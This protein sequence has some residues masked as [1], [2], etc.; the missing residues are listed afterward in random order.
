VAGIYQRDGSKFWMARFKGPDGD[1]TARSTKTTNSAEALKLAFLWEGTAQTL[2]IDN[3]QAAQIERVTKDLLEKF[4]GSKIEVTPT[5]D[6]FNA[7]I[8]RMKKTRAPKSAERYRRVIVLFLDHLGEQRAGADIRSITGPEIQSFVD[9]EIARGMSSGTVALNGK[10]IRAVFASAVRAGLIER[11]PA[12]TVELPAIVHE[13]RAAFTVGE[14]RAILAAAGKSDWVSAV[15]VGAYC[16]AR[17]GDAANMKWDNIDLAG[18]LIKY[19]PEKTRRKKKVI[20]IPMHKALFAHLN[21]LASSEAAQKSPFLCPSLAGRDVSGRSGLSAEFMDV[22]AKA[23]VDP[24]RTDEREGQGHRFAAKSFHSL[25]HFFNSELANRGV[26]I[27]TRTTL[28]GH[29][30]ERQNAV[31]THLQMRTLRT[32]VAKLPG[33]AKKG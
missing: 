10:I 4:S 24:E 28:T 16:G 29:S 6:Y 3:V 7:W 21:E 27:D 22:L 25:R 18:K 23:G 8:E 12:G 26:P 11:N 13:E 9:A 19:L 32:A 31:Y 5:R 1:W 33:T 15:L 14:L 17:L 20:V 30:S 2:K